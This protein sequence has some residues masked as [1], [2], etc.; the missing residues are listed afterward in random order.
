MIS[1]AVIWHFHSVEIC[2][3]SVVCIIAFFNIYKMFFYSPGALVAAISQCFVF[4][5]CWDVVKFEFGHCLID[6]ADGWSIASSAM[7]FWAVVWHIGTVASV[8]VCTML[9]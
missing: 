5:Q 7:T 8:N 3:C 4:L 6:F 1:V 9:L 2:F